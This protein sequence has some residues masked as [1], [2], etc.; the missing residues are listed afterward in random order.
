MRMNDNTKKIIVKMSQYESNRYICKAVYASFDRVTFVLYLQVE[1]QVIRIFGWNQFQFDDDVFA[2]A[3]LSWH[4][5][6]FFDPFWRFFLPRKI[7]KYFACCKL[8]I[9]SYF[10]NKKTNYISFIRD[11]RDFVYIFKKYMLYQYSMTGGNLLLKSYSAISRFT[12]FAKW[13]QEWRYS[14]YICKIVA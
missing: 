13:L 3:S 14:R 5:L 1:L 8:I 6:I 9:L 11:I 2:Y 4:G 10:H 7:C 12:C